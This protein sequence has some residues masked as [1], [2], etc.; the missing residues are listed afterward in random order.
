M[1][2]KKDFGGID[3]LR[4][5]AEEI[6]IPDIMLYNVGDYLN[7]KAN[8]IKTN[9]LVYPNGLVLWVPPG[10]Y[11]SACRLDL[12]NWPFDEHMC[13]LKFGS[14]TYDGYVLDIRPSSKTILL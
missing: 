11:K 3:V 12:K 13:F 2:N 7:M 9:P 6:F 10:T 4:V 5:S 8:L 1:W 14:W